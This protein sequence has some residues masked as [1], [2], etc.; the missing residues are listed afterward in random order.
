MK[1]DIH[2][3]INPVVFIDSSNKTEFA[4]FSTL[5]SKETKKI[6][7]VEHFIIHVDVSSASHPFYTGEKMS[8]V[9]EANFPSLNPSRLRRDGCG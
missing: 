4:T 7:G 3:K 2:P 6:K 5:S 9:C 1:T 8:G